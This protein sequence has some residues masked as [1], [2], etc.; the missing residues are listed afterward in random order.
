MVGD[1]RMVYSKNKSMRDELVLISLLRH[2]ASVFHVGR[3]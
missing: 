1:M 2:A 3:C